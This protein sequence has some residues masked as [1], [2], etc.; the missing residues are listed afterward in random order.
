VATPFSSG[1]VSVQ[2]YQKGL[3]TRSELQWRGCE[4]ICRH[5]LT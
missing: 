5:C 1:K 2:K 4:F 3:V